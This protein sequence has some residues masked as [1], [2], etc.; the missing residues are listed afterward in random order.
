MDLHFSHDSSHLVA[1]CA[2][3]S[4]HVA[5]SGRRLTRSKLL[6][7]SP[8]SGGHW[9]GKKTSGRPP[10]DLVPSVLHCGKIPK[11][12]G[13]NLVS[14]H[15]SKNQKKKQQFVNETFEMRERCKGVHCVDL[16]ESFPT[17]ISL[18]NLASIQ[19][20]TSLVNFA[21]SP[22]TD[23]PGLRHAQADACDQAE[24]PRGRGPERLL[25][26]HEPHH[27]ERVGHGGG[28]APRCEEPGLGHRYPERN[29]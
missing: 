20:R 19:P 15:V 28:L 25:Q 11:T 26:L 3:Q 4:L 12:F 24:G 22:R 6:A 14:E 10:E 16:G 7:K 9:P 21:R 5:E 18:Q 13:Q 27:R 1:A 8:H 29:L 2:D 23:P 17:S